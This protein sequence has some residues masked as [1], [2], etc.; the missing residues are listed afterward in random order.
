MTIEVNLAQILTLAPS[1]RSSYREAFEQSQPVLD[2]YG[3]SD[4][5]LRVAH[6]MAQVLHECGGLTIQ[7][8]N[9]NYS[10]ERLP[11]VWPSRFLPKGPL[12][13]QQFA[14]NPQKLAN[15]V[16][17]KRMGNQPGTDDGFTFRGRGLIQLTGR[18]SYTHATQLIRQWRPE[19]P[20]FS[21]MPDEVLSAQ[22]CVAV[23]AAEWDEKQCNALA[24]SDSLRKVT[25]AI[26]GGLIGLAERE[27]WLRRTKHVW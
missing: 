17:G 2:H 15:E 5:S 27:E 24:D 10:P 25:Q 6:F 26:N 9:L 18:E 16:Y 14:H 22:W 11:K 21:E 12:D 20:D 8:E 4:N 7:F 13:P 3:I 19:A 1:A 23:A